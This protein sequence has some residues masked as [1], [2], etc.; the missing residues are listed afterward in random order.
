MVQVKVA[1]RF[2]SALM[3]LMAVAAS[4]D[5]IVRITDLPDGSQADGTSTLPRISAD[6]RTIAFST[7]A[8]NLNGIGPGYRGMI[9]DRTARKKLN[10]LSRV[11]PV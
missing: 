7:S 10:R 3:C 2:V 5:N 9:Y 8:A 11:M 1:L 4:A 6:G